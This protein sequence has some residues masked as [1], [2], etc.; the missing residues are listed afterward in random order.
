MREPGLLGLHP[1]N[2][3]SGALPETRRTWHEIVRATRLADGKAA[4]YG[5]YDV[6]A[7]EALVNVGQS[8]DTAEFAV[9]GIQPWRETLGRKRYPDATRLY[10]TS[11]SGDNVQSRFHRLPGGC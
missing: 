7:N 6:A 8:H 4:S 5:V 2:G 11:D 10:I 9:A 1:R 3:V